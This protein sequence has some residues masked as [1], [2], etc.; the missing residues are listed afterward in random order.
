M[1]PTPANATRGA[2]GVGI[3]RGCLRNRMRLVFFN[4]NFG[5]EFLEQNLSYKILFLINQSKLLKFTVFY[6]IIRCYR[7]MK[8]NVF[9]KEKYKN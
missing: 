9:F 2:W 7:T 6:F 5:I 4:K 8:S 1:G 3:H